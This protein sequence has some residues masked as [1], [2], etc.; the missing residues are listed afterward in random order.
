MSKGKSLHFALQERISE[1]VAAGVGT[2]KHADKELFPAEKGK[3][4]YGDPNKIYSIKTAEGY[5]QVADEFAKWAQKQGVNKFH[6]LDQDLVGRYLQ[7]RRD[8][9]KSAYTVKHD[10]AALNKVCGYQI[11]AADYGLPDR[12]LEDITRSRCKTKPPYTEAQLR[13]NGPQILIAESFG[14]RRQSML[15]I[16]KDSFYIKGN[17]LF[18]AVTEKGGRYRYI[19]CLDARKSEVL[20]FL[21]PG[22][23]ERLYHPKKQDLQQQGDPLFQKY[24]KNIDNH[25]LR[26]QY[27]SCKLDELKG[28]KPSTDGAKDGLTKNL[29]HNRTS[30]LAHYIR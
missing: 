20:S 23:Q 28:I 12:K 25:S 26:A 6:K 9:G 14:I 30:V 5:R 15:V 10:M 17:S 27:A 18:L 24:D 8:S 11:T 7:E 13:H 2:S 19:E 16:S 29:G 1:M 4:S 3:T 21:G 22:V